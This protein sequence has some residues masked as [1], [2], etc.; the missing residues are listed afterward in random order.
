MS[1]TDA[2]PRGLVC[3]AGSS[4]RRSPTIARTA[5]TVAT[6]P[7][8]RAATGYGRP[9]KASRREGPAA[10]VVAPAQ[11]LGPSVKVNGIGAQCEGE[12]RWGPV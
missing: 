10:A 8:A 2:R 12:R 7:V 5:P 4:P 1:G 9:P 3:R 11:L 6:A